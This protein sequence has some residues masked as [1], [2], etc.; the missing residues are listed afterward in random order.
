[1]L[2]NLICI[3]LYVKWKELVNLDGM[4]FELVFFIFIIYFL[5]SFKFDV[6]ILVMLKFKKKDRFYWI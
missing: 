1:M 5:K 3:R 2:F 6:V 4:F